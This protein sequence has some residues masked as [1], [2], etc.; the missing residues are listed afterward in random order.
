MCSELFR[1]VQTGASSQPKKHIRS[2]GCGSRARSNALLMLRALPLSNVPRV[3]GCFA[4]IGGPG[5]GACGGFVGD[6]SWPVLK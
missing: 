6:Y 5:V 1:I 2:A 4:A 3:V